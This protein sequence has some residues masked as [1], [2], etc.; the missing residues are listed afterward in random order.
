MVKHWKEIAMFLGAFCVLV[1]VILLPAQDR[2]GKC[3]AAGGITLQTPDGWA[4]I[5]AERIKFQ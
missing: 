1:V 5:K 2:W 4:C 3:E